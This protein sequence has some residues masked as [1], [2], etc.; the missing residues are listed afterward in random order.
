MSNYGGSPASEIAHQALSE[1]KRNNSASS[2]KRQNSASSNEKQKTKGGQSSA[3]NH[4]R[5]RSYSTEDDTESHLDNSNKYNSDG[6]FIVGLDNESQQEDEDEWKEEETAEDDDDDDDEL[7]ESAIDANEVGDITEDKLRAQNS[8]SAGLAGGNDYNMP[9]VPPDNEETSI[10][11]G[12]E[13]NEGQG[14]DEDEVPRRRRKP[15]QEVADGGYQN[16]DEDEYEDEDEEVKEQKKKERLIH[17]KIERW[18]QARAS[19]ISKS[20]TSQRVLETPNQNIKRLI[21]KNGELERA[22]NM[23]V[24]MGSINQALSEAFNEENTFLK[25]LQSI[26]PSALTKAD[27]IAGIAEGMN[28]LSKLLSLYESKRDFKVRKEIEGTGDRKSQVQ[29]NYDKTVDV[30]REIVGNQQI[31]YLISDTELEEI[32]ERNELTRDGITQK[33]HA[34]ENGE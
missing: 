27:S 4:G 26:P 34:E 23:S 30:I 31:K 10:E 1:E 13:E 32:T 5:T 9:N 28:V 14:D 11:S 19:K 33:D 22:K 21:R 24:K 2:N 20:T 12:D 16:Q 7:D 17:D 6:G 25:I 3:S 18:N 15:Q 8:Q 29:Q